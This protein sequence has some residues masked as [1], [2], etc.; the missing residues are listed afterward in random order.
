RRDARPVEVADRAEPPR[1]T[2]E[3]KRGCAELETRDLQ[4]RRPRV[5]QKIATRD[6]DI[7]RARTDVGGDVPRAKVEELGVV[8]PVE[9]GQLFA[10]ATH[11]VAGFGEHL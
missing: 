3:T 10:V 6:A 7:E 1:G 4:R 2:R 5:D 11:R 9:H 8:R